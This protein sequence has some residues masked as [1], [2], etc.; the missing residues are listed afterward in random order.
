[1]VT[2]SNVVDG[3]VRHE[4]LSVNNADSTLQIVKERQPIRLGSLAQADI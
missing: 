3:T 4:A 2:Q 1:L